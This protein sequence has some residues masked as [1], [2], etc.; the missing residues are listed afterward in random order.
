MISLYRDM[1]EKKIDTSKTIRVTREQ[2]KE[3][4]SL[5]RMNMSFSE[6]LDDIMKKANVKSSAAALKD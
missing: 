5:G 2:Y 1:E 4:L 3:L 6:V